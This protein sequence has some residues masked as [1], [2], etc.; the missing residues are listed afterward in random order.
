MTLPDGSRRRCLLGAALLAAATATRS[1]QRPRDLR[2]GLV[3]YLSTR[4]TLD[5]YQPLRR[6]LETELKGPVTLYTAADFRALADNARAGEYALALMP[7]HLARIAV[8]DWGH[9]FVA[10]SSLTSEVQLIA[11]RDAQPALPDGLRGRRI[12]AIDPLS[13]GTL[14]L[15]RW[16]V[17]QG[18]VP[19]RDVQID[20]LR[21]IGSAVIAVQRGDAVALTG[22]IG[23]LRDLALGDTS[24][25]VKIATV[26]AIPT[27]VF[28]AHPS[29]PATEVADWQ[30]ALLSFVPPP[31]ADPGLSRKP[32]I[33]GSIR[34][35][36]AIEGYA[37][38][39]R[40]LLAQPPGAPRPAETRRP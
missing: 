12:A 25:L 22:A 19:G 9:V 10:R 1:Q 17:Q 36:D 6:H 11:R 38:E 16:L 15:Q 30:A 20:H 7:P 27:P 28:V 37:Q 5:L 3:P 32:F 2:V 8:N 21:S 23:Q 34:E 29:I 40:R 13:L 24:D 33:A 18:L 31:S 14:T 26:A 4:A 39:A 35:L